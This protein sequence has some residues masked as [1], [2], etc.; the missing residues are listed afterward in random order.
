MIWVS[1]WRHQMETFSA[2]LALYA[3][4]S[5]VT[6]EFPHKGQ[7][8]GVSMFSLICSWINAR[9]NNREAGDL[10]RH[11]AH[12]DVIVMLVA[13]TIHVSAYYSFNK[14]VLEWKKNKIHYCHWSGVYLLIEMHLQEFMLCVSRF[15]E[16]HF[17]S[18]LLQ[19][20]YNFGILEHLEKVLNRYCCW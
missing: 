2:L 15:H 9:V 11:R 14:N 12:Y 20:H 7:W 16:Q 19:V 13:V 6:G 10:R 5:S 18:S 4:N 1:L 8:R 3:G 17:E